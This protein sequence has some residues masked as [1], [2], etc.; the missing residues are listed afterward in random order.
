LIQ[1]DQPSLCTSNRPILGTFDLTTLIEL[2][3]VI[4]I[5]AV[6][7]V[8]P[9]ACLGPRKKAARSAFEQ[10]PPDRSGLCFYADDNKD[11]IVTLLVYQTRQP[12]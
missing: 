8:L 3:V 2:L 10:C 5:I 11:D 9:P 7:A 4:A 12:R 1:S 6:L